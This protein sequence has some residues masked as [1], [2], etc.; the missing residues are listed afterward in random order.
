MT[1]STRLRVAAIAAAGAVALGGLAGCSSTSSS[2][3]SGDVKGTLHILVSSGTGSDQAFKTL[4]ADFEKKYPGVKVDFSSVPNESFAASRSS[5]LT[6]NNLDI[7]LAQPV[8]V[9]SWAHGSET[10][11]SLA[12]DAGLFLDLSDKSFIKNFTP[13]VIDQLTYKGKTYTVP[14]GLSYYTGVFYNKKIFQAN[15][16][17]V[18]TTYSE[19]QADAAKL[20]AAGITPLGIGGKD[21]WPAGLD[22]MA[23]VQSLY[24]TAD[25]KTALAKGIWSGSVKLTDTKPVQV[26]DRTQYLYSIA[27]KNFAGVPYTQI[28]SGFANGDYAMTI[29]GTWDQTTIDAAVAGKFEYGYFPFPGSDNAADNTTLG[30]K[31]EIRMAVA[32]GGPNQAAALAYLDFYSQKDEYTKF[33]KTAG[34]APAEPGIDASDFLKSIASATATFSPAWDTIWYPN[35]AAAAP[36]QVAFNYTGIAP[37]GTG[38][39]KDAASAAADAWKAAG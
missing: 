4:N 20:Q 23:A 8:A 36:V 17:T 6:A 21:S 5:R 39:V 1:I 22:M 3:A 15:G 31:A 13:S 26:L 30:G 25:D 18:P 34:F 2:D 7:T 27:E 33:V 19:F 11:D 10:D 37:L 32:K 35:T 12:A 38:S 14:T 9:P 28:P 24:P 29:D 16:I